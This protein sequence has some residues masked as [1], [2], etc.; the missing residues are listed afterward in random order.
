M[1]K[2]IFRNLFKGEFIRNVT[3]VTGSSI[4]A[5]FLTIALSPIITR[6]YTPEEYGVLTVFV[7]II[8]IL[9]AISSLNYQK[10]IP[11]AESDRRAINTLI[12]AFFITICFTLIIGFVLMFFGTPIIDVLDSSAIEKYIYFI[13]IGVCLAGSYKIFIQWAYRNR[14][15]KVI[16]RTRIWQ[17]IMSNIIKV[18]LGVL[19]FGP[20]GLI[21]G[22]TVG[23]SA[24]LITLSKN[25]L[26][27]KNLVRLI[28]LKDIRIMAKRFVKFPLYSAPSDLVF[29]TSMQMPPILL[30]SIFGSSVV[31]LFGLANS[32]VGLPVALISNSFSQVFYAEIANIGKTN[33]REIKRLSIKLL[34]NLSLLGLIPLSI[35]LIFSPMLFSFVFGE[36][37]FEAGKYAQILSV[38]YYFYFIILPFGRILEVLEKQKEGLFLNILRIILIIIT[39]SLAAFFKLSSGTTITLFSVASSLLYILLLIVVF[40]ILNK[41][42]KK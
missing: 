25:I 30:T 42:L 12:L 13:P 27:N 14:S 5:Q 11:I 36:E 2:R 24:G 33:P 37:W 31:G 26:K 16:A 4:F 8:T 18:L 6:I 7:A 32:I 41:L 19:K 10:A 15:Y 28:N 21:L 39:F 38:M 1:L 23:D 17:S 29:M 20:V 3:L 34:K 9:S 40:K 35:L 22:R